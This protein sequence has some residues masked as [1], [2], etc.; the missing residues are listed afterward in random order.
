MLLGYTDFGA[1]ML[2][3]ARAGRAARL[4]S[5]LAILIRVW[6]DSEGAHEQQAAVL[7]SLVANEHLVTF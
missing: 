6:G 4:G 2:H 3:L 5:K 1:G 7:N